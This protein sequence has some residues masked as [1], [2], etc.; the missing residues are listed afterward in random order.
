MT[1]GYRAVSTRDI[2][3][4]VGLTQPALYYHF[5]GKEALYAA[6]LEDELATMATD[7]NAAGAL[8]ASPVERLVAIATVLAS[9]GEHDLAQMFHDLR[10]E[11]SLENRRRI[12]TAFRDA[13][14]RPIL[15]AIDGIAAEGTIDPGAI[16]LERGEAAML[17]L[18]NVRTLVEASRSPA[19]GP[20]R[21]PDAIGRLASRLLIGALS[22]REAS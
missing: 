1:R 20:E 5:G 8:D 9:G 21:S 2:A 13:M 12:G 18:S 15:A 22:N 16:G 4:A 7:L 6:V 3:D 14:L 11:I 19:G 10:H 17:L